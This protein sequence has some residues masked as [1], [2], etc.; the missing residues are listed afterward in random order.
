MSDRVASDLKLGDLAREFAPA[1]PAIPSW[2]AT[3]I[4]TTPG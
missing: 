3:P 4:C 1:L 2:R